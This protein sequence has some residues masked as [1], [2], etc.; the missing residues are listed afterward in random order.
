[1]PERH[2]DLMGDVLAAAID[3]ADQTGE[4]VRVALGDEARRKGRELGESATS[5][6]QVI[7]SVGYEP[8]DEGDGS[9]ILTNCPF[10]RL[11]ASH[12]SIICQ[13]NVAL[14]EGAAEGAGD[15]SHTI[16]FDPSA[17]HCCV[18]LIPLDS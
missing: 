3:T 8:Q 14:L 5:F 2:Y 11:A 1:F 18:R 9:V 15:C 16:S 6:A 17:G 13:A 10:H 7:E 4:G 12:T